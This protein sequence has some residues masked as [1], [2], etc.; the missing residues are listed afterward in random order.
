MDPRIGAYFKAHFVAAHQQ[1]GSFEVVNN[2][3]ALR[4]NGG[5]VASY[6]CTPDGRVIDAL[7]GPVS[8]D[9]LLAEAKWSIDVYEKAAPAALAQALATAHREAAEDLALSSSAGRSHS[10]RIHQLLAAHPLPL[11]N[12]IYKEIFEQILGQRVTPPTTETARVQLGFESAKRRQLPVLLVLY[13]KGD[14]AGTQRDW[15][16]VVSRGRPDSTRLKALAEC[17]VVLIM[18]L[19]LMPEL[20]QHLGVRPFAAPDASLPLFVVTRSTGHEIGAVTTWDKLHD[21]V[22]LMAQGL[23]QE[24]KERP[25]DPSQLAK[26]C[27]LLDSIDADLAAQARELKN[28]TSA[29]GT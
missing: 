17:Y 3:G 24:A 12:E 9:T 13:E 4:K 10:L 14:H 26:L 25:R 1:V 29:G 20:S 16:T 2:F 21:L 28:E 22:E 23:L 11:L 8:A 19:D 18:R 27:S 7:A 15:N 5:N 6:F